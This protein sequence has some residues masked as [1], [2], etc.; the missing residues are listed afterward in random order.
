[1]SR[2]QQWDIVS[3]VGLTALAVAAARAIESHRADALIHDPYAAAFVEAAD[4]PMPMPTRPDEQD[5]AVT[6]ALDADPSYG[7]LWTRV[8]DHMGVRSRFFDDYFRRACRDG[9]RQA[10]ILAAGLD[11]RAFRLDWSDG[12]RVFELDQPRVLEFKDA[13]LSGY[14]AQ[15][16]CERHVVPVDLREEWSVP[17]RAVG[18][19]PELPTAWLAEGLLPYLPAPAQQNLMHTIAALSAPGSYVAVEH[20][21][22][23]Q[24][25][26]DDPT[27]NSAS[28]R[29]GIDMSALFP[30][31][32][33][34]DQISP[35][36]WLD[37]RR[38]VADSHQVDVIASR[39]GRRFQPF[40][41]SMPV[42]D[43]Q[44]V[45]AYAPTDGPN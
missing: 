6:D 12:M 20:M 13:V 28:R 43:Y 16:Q 5:D 35:D 17:L 25:V 45:T 21:P 11:T 30:D 9:V 2:Y 23:V 15:P 31:N 44:F 1:M 33:A 22:N 3:G 37:E 8:A 29:F 18:F 7:A 19:D 4:P 10:V 32:A 34:Q 38:W 24:T 26:F 42:A 40:S 36:E 14:G 27:I 41:E 39:Y